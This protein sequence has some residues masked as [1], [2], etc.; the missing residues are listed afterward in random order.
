MLISCA[1]SLTGIMVGF[2]LKISLVLLVLKNGNINCRYFV[3]FVM[4]WHLIIDELN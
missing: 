1:S 2:T 4:L 3:G